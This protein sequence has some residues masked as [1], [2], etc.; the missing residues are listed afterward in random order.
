MKIHPLAG[1]PAPQDLLVDIDKLPKEYYARK[2]DITDS[3][4]RVSFGTSD[5][6]GSSLRGA[7]NEAR[8]HPGDLRIPPQPGYHRSPVHRQRHARAIDLEVGNQDN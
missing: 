6:R 2:P 8:Y 3:A 4:E 5:H 7:F 1:K